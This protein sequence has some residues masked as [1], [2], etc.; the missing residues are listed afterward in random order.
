MHLLFG[1]SAGAGSNPEVFKNATGEKSLREDF[2]EL[3]SREDREKPNQSSAKYISRVMRWAVNDSDYWQ[4][5]NS[6]HFCSESTWSEVR[7]QYEQS[8]KEASAGRRTRSGFWDA[9]IKR[10]ADDNDDFEF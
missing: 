7:R 9:R 4:F 8:K 1:G 5:Y 3:L 2:A 10:R 6:K